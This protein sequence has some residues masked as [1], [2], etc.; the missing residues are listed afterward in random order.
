MKTRYLYLLFA[1]FT[2]I[3][4]SDDDYTIVKTKNVRVYTH[5]TQTKMSLQEGQNVTQLKWDDGDDI[6]IMTAKEKKEFR[7]QADINQDGVVEF[8]PRT[9]AL[10]TDAEGETVYAFYPDHV[11]NNIISENTFEIGCFTGSMLKQD[12]LQDLYAVNK[13][14][15]GEAYLKFK[16]LFTY[17]KIKLP[18]SKI[19]TNDASNFILRSTSELEARSLIFDINKEKL[20]ELIDP[21][22]SIYTNLSEAE[23]DDAYVTFYF[24]ILP[25]PE[26]TVL[27]FNY[28]SISEEMPKYLFSRAVPSDGMKVGHM[29][30][31]D[32]ESDKIQLEEQ[33]ER[34]ALIDFYNS[35]NGP[36]WLNQENWC[37]DALLEDWYGISGISNVVTLELIENNLKGQ[38]PSSIA[39]L[40]D[41]ASLIDLRN[42]DLYG[43]IPQEIKTHPQWSTLGW[44]M[45]M[46]QYPFGFN[47]DLP[48]TNE[49]PRSG[50]DFSDGNSNLYLPDKEVT[51][52]DGSKTQLM[53]LIRQNKI[54]QIIVHSRGPYDSPYNISEARVNLHLDYQN[55]GLGTIVEIGSY[56]SE[57]IDDEWKT[58]AQSLPVENFIFIDEANN[59]Y[60]NNN[61]IIPIPQS[62]WL[63]HNQGD[64]FLVSSEGELIDY[65]KYIGGKQELEDW[66]CH[67]IDSV[68]RVYCGEPEEHPI[69]SRDLYTSTDYSRDGEVITL[70]EASVGNGIDLVFLG[71]A[72]VDKDMG[73]GGLY[74]QRMREGMEQFFAYE[75]Y[76]SLRNR[77]NVYAV[78]VVSP[79]A[80]FVLGAEHRINESDAVCFEY[81]QKIPGFSQPPMVSVIYNQILPWRSYTVMYSDGAFVAYIMN[82]NN[83]VLNHESGGHGF[84]NLSDEYIEAGNENLTLPEI[85]K[86]IMDYE[87]ENFGWGANVDWRNDPATVRWSHFL[88]DSRYDNEGLGLYEGARYYGYGAYR[89]TE[90]SMMR[91]NDSPFNAP[92]RE[93]IY[94]RVMQMS[95]GSSWTYDY[96]DFV[97]FDAPSRNAATTRSLRQAPSAAQV[98]KWKKSHRPPVRVKGT[99]RDA[100]KNSIVVPYR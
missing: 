22:N 8:R 36:Q 18:K 95:E 85:E 96:E 51:L 14:E 79:N 47:C 13:I 6:L 90:N 44:T 24:A 45:I 83:E 78:K 77:F 58:F 62:S 97:E 99:W 61:S 93:Q 88:Q 37:S 55:K 2:I 57:P 75:P 87:W 54:N 67:K 17:L 80:E 59:G 74:E 73:D 20:T 30:T 3:G 50:F 15:N 68:L 69:Y 26:N 53:P 40:M 94:K 60:Q 38:L 46:G 42:N 11:V 21:L 25:Q 10:S 92:S 27:T 86:E 19:D 65:F 31:M 89:P 4:C 56:W 70:Q 5:T 63:N 35:T 72:F 1:F 39:P 64:V 81:A 66:Y 98:E 29:Y 84:A 49:S 71:E 91:Y 33:Q 28:N 32:M 34:N 76:R 23:T 100:R 43:R 12:M 16:H 9:E 7:Y 41:H 82:E 48:F 52:L